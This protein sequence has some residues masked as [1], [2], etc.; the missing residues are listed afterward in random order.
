MIVGLV[1]GWAGSLAVT[2]FLEKQLFQVTPTDVATF[3]V[4]SV[5]LTVAALAAC[6]FPARRAAPRASIRWLHFAAIE[7]RGC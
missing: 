7:A 5:L 2:R 1:A 3:D 4:V 6:Y